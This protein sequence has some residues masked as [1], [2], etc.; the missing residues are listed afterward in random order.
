M[1]SDSPTIKNIT[2]KN[3]FAVPPM[4]CFHRADADGYVSEFNVEHYRELARGG[5]GLIIV[6]ATA[7][8]LRSRLHETEL[9]L[10]EDGQIDG[11]RRIVDAIHAEGAKAFIQLVHAGGNGIDTTPDAPSAMT[12]RENNA[13]E[14]TQEAID[15]V[16]EK[17]AAAAV[18][19]KAAGFDGLE[20]HGCHGYLL[21][22]F[23]STIYNVRTDAYGEDHAL[24]TKQVFKA[25]RKACGDDF[26]VGI[27]LAAFEPTLEDGLRN[28]K[29]I[30][31][32][33]DFLDISYGM[34]SDAHPPVDF[35]CSPAVYGAM[36]IKRELPDM[37]VFAVHNINSREDAE[38]ALATGIDMVDI[39]KAALV[40]PA[41]AAHALADEPCGVCLHCKNRCRWDPPVMADMSAVCPGKLLFEKDR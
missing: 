16:I 32:L 31:D 19:A 21:S 29:A 6:E 36:M 10:W 4:V 15:D 8:T 23:F 12:Y 14:M 25:V 22:E 27:R 3:R 13:V 17:F 40:D 11:M 39:G 2:I 20:L 38:N 18:R 37:P 34:D 5:F 28:A 7:I 24:I 26:I 30:A 35:P 9:G 41:F 1:L 33:T